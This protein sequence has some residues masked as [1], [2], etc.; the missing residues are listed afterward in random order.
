MKEHLRPSFTLG[1]NRRG[2]DRSSAIC[3]EG[4]STPRLRRGPIRSNG[5]SVSLSS[6]VIFASIVMTALFAGG[7]LFFLLQENGGAQGPDTPR[8]HSSVSSGSGTDRGTGR[9]GSESGSIDGG[10]SVDGSS[11]DW[12]DGVR[13]SNGRVTPRNGGG[14]TTTANGTSLNPNV[15]PG[16]FPTSGSGQNR[17]DGS[18]GSDGS[19]TG[20]TGNHGSSGGGTS[21]RGTSG[22]GTSDGGSLGDGNADGTGSAGDTTL[23]PAVTIQGSIKAVDSEGTQFAEESGILEA[24]VT[25]PGLDEVR[26]WPVTGGNWTATV[27]DHAQ[28]RFTG[29]TLRERRAT[30]SPSIPVTASAGARFELI[31]EWTSQTLLQVRSRATGEILCDLTLLRVPDWMRNS[32][33]HPGAAITTDQQWTAECSP[34]P[35]SAEGANTGSSVP[36]HVHSPGYAWGRILLDTTTGGDREILLDAGGAIELTFEGGWDRPGAVLRL[37][38]LGETQPYAEVPVIGQVM[39]IDGILPG[40]YDVAVETGSWAQSPLV[41]GNVEL[42]VLT[43]ELLPVLLP[44]D[45]IEDEERVPFAGTVF[46]PAGWFLDDFQ[47]RIRPIDPGR[48]V[49]EETQHIPSLEM[50]ITEVSGGSLYEWQADL[51]EPGNFGLLVLPIGYGVNVNVPETGNIGAQ[52]SLPPP[53]PVEVHTVL[54][55]TE[56]PASPLM[57]RWTPMRE[58]GVPGAGAL[59]VT[60]EPGTNI[61]LFDA[62]IG[63][64]ILS[65]S[66]SAYR[67]ASRQITLSESGPNVFT[68]ELQPAH[69]VSLSL[70]DDQTPVPW[71]IGWHAH[72]TALEGTTGQVVT[73]GRIGIQYRILVSNPGWYTLTM[74]DIDGFLPIPPQPIEILEGEIID[75]EVLLQRE[76]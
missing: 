61:F 36:Y 8:G 32:R 55:G 38:N 40:A 26:E 14:R 75:H 33:P 64:V 58:Q 23:G 28:I 9:T 2:R 69:G 53:V 76:L 35:L 68:F 63:G 34:I 18:G 6:R 37:R 73:R 19:R 51:V 62:P 66:D 27:P 39:R 45:T 21:G 24:R 56:E 57:I 15:G 22:G 5:R 30:V 17:V 44:V 59:S 31:G 60:A 4:S 70:F 20:S 12:V 74:P 1:Q 29:A 46:V 25:G 3:D 72:L 42:T 71:D 10:T 50:A 67:P 47:L 48:N 49:A 52:I 16:G 65:C 13:G 11:V 41:L 7:A 54:A 43:G